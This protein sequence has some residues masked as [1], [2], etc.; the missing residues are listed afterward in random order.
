MG[1]GDGSED[2]SH[3]TGG[4]GGFHPQGR[5]IQP[6][7]SGGPDPVSR[8]AAPS[9]GAFLMEV[10]GPGSFLG[11]ETIPGEIAQS[12]ADCRVNALRRRKRSG[13]PK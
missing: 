7:F 10:F 3:E 1:G 6:G 12:S 4:T 5:L 2:R 13:R 8:S 9:P 11:K